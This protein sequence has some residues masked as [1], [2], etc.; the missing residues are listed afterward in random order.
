MPRVL[1]ISPDPVQ[2]YMAG[3]GVRSWELAHALAEHCDVTL[4]VPNTPPVPSHPNV[5]VVSFDLEEGDLRPFAARADVLII[6]GPILHYHPYLRDLG[7]PIVVD[8][9]IPDLLESLVR[10][11][12]DNFEEWIP[13]YEEY[14]RVQLELLR[15]GDFFICASERQRDYWLGWLH[16]QKRLNPHTYRQDPTFRKLIDVVPFGLPPHPPQRHA[17]VLRGVHPA[18]DLESK[19]VLWYGG[20]WDWLDPLTVIKAVAR[21]APAHPDIRLCFVALNPP[22]PVATSMSMLDR[23]IALSRD[24]GLYGHVVLFEDWVPYDKRADYLLESDLAVVAHPDHIETHFSF[25]TRVL[26]CIWAG[27]PI[28]ITEGD[29]MAQMVRSYGI[30]LTVPPQDVEAMAAAIEEIL[31]RRGGKSAFAHAFEAIRPSISWNQ[32]IKPLVVF[33]L[34]PYLAHDK[35]HYLTEVER[36]SRDKDKFIQFLSQEIARLQEYEKTLIRYHRFPLFRIYFWL[37]R[38]LRIS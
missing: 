16:A 36:I 9:Y 27:L 23:A 26:D 8:L 10:H 14:L 19:I 11:S 5:T 21:L 17:H 33:C 30:G 6:R 35:G 29:V 28:V 13:A 22:T 37:K 31:Y 2:P 20:L 34:Q 18:V 25:R 3:P 7:V 12:S 24:L 1:I 15:A 32:V 4:A 38:T